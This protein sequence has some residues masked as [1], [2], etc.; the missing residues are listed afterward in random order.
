MSL[1][2]SYFTESVEIQGIPFFLTAEKALMSAVSKYRSSHAIDSDGKPKPY[3]CYIA[4]VQ[5]NGLKNHKMLFAALFANQKPNP[6]VIARS[7]AAIQFESAHGTNIYADFTEHGSVNSG[8][9]PVDEVVGLRDAIELKE[10]NLKPISQYDDTKVGFKVTDVNSNRTVLFQFEPKDID[11][12]D[13][14]KAYQASFGCR[15]TSNN[16]FDD[17]YQKFSEDELMVIKRWLREKS[18]VVELESLLTKIHRNE[19]YSNLYHELAQHGKLSVNQL[20]Q[21]II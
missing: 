11:G 15:N 5:L 18:E 2:Y 3:N 6:I 8:I 21:I 9:L 7:Y 19:H 13:G 20:H 10:M 1:Y 4:T 14:E 12:E 16:K 17:S